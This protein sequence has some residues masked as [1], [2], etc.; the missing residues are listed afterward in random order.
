MPTPELPIKT[1]SRPR[2]ASA[3]SASAFL[4][5]GRRNSRCP[6]P[7]SLRGR[8]RGRRSATVRTGV[9]PTPDAAS[10]IRAMSFSDAGSDV[11]I[12]CSWRKNGSPGALCPST[13]TMTEREP[14]PRLH[15]AVERLVIFGDLPLADACFADEQNES[16]RL[17][18]FLGELRGPGA[19]GAQA[20]RREEHAERRVLAL[21]GAL[22]PLRQR[23]IRRVIAEKPARHAFAPSEAES[24]ANCDGSITRAGQAFCRRHKRGPRYAGTNISR[25]RSQSASLPDCLRP[26]AGRAWGRKGRPAGSR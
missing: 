2:A 13:R 7:P 17:G 21:D 5:S 12:Q 1:G 15:P 6:S 22:E 4:W 9:A 3:S 10:K 20:R 23:L 25:D 16:V 26:R 24:I 8:G 18:Q 19:A 14:P 11:T